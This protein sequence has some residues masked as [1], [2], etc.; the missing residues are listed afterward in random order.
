MALATD[1]KVSDG[2]HIRDLVPDVIAV[3]VLPYALRLAY[4]EVSGLRQCDVDELPAEG[5][6]RMYELMDP[7]LEIL[8]KNAKSIKEWEDI[9]SSRYAQSLC[10]S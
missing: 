3:D 5:A 1:R 9:F 7:G 6:I 4:C 10:R 8:Q 2:L